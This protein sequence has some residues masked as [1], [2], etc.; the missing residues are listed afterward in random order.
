MTEGCVDRCYLDRL[1][2]RLDWTT[3]HCAFGELMSTIELLHQQPACRPHWG[4]SLHIICN[5]IAIISAHGQ[6]TDSA[7]LLFAR[8]QQCVTLWRTTT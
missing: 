6:K 2:P 1:P 4:P 8:V 7:Y 3:P 5:K